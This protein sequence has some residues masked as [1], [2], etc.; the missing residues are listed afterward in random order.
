MVALYALAQM[1]REGRVHGYQLSRR[2]AERTQGAWRPSPG[3]IYP[4]LRG[5]VDRG[6]ARRVGVG[7]RR[8]YRI[9]P[10]G[11]ELLR[12]VRRQVGA[13]APGA[14][15]LSVLWAEVAGA[16]DLEQFLMRRL[17]RSLDAISGALVSAPASA[18]AGSASAELR[19]AAI[20]ELASRLDE[21]RGRGAS[22]G[23]VV[24]V[25]EG[26]AHG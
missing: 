8:E 12:R 22:V 26:G 16:A 1:E 13:G 14:P 15:D 23:A 6:L 7:R 17:R 25:H 3:T 11:R 18:R 21:L 9:T 5:L 24:R 4:S 19:R 10:A 2:I 20:A